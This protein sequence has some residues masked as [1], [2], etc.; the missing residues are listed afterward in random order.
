VYNKNC[1]HSSEGILYSKHPNNGCRLHIRF[2]RGYQCI[3][4]KCFTG[5]CSHITI[6]TNISCATRCVFKG[7]LQKPN[8]TIQCLANPKSQPHLA[9][10][11]E[12]R[13]P[14]SILDSENSHP[15]TVAMDNALVSNDSSEA[16]NANC[17]ESLNSLTGHF[18]LRYILG[19][20]LAVACEYHLINRS[21]AGKVKYLA[22]LINVSRMSATRARK[23]IGP[24]CPKE[25]SL[26]QAKRYR[27]I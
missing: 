10:S 22:R 2:L 13:L 27:T 11:D 9:G 15:W 12:I 19:C 20:Y 3:L 7:P 17:P 25:L 6:A 23:N 26:N 8:L 24:G 14:N 21:L 5:V 16:V 4:P 1:R 18:L